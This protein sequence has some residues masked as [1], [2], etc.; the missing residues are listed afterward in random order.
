MNLRTT[1]FAL[2]LGV[3]ALHGAALFT[4]GRLGQTPV[5]PPTLSSLALVSLPAL[6]TPQPT[7]AVPKPV[8]AQK[9]TPSK[10]APLKPQPVAKP[11]AQPVLKATAKSTTAPEA[12]SAPAPTPPTPSKRSA[13]EQADSPLTT[14]QAAGNSHDAPAREGP[15]TPPTQV[16]G[17][18]NTPRP[19]YPPLSIEMGE[20]GSVRLRAQIDA[21]GRPS[22]VT[23]VKGSGFPRLD[24]AA[25]AAVRG[26]RFNPARRGNEAIPFTYTFSVDFTL[27]NAQS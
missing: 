16:G 25:V 19:N 2:L 9:T 4:L 27:R 21:E 13:A 15:V 11:I 10:P 14:G 8:S 3:T 12:P 1:H 22:D 17:Y 24:R 20:E 6:G 26:W 7:P 18:A 5:T 23:V